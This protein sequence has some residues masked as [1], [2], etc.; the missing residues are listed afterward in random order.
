MT[1]EHEELVKSLK[2][3]INII[4]TLYERSKEQTKQLQLEKEDLIHKL[5]SKEISFRDLEKKYEVLKLAK[6]IEA[7]GDNSHDA[8]IKMNRIVREIDK[9][10]ALLNK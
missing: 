8:K 7:S 10:I 9:C 5:D 2:D 6:T 3:K 4:I 1:S